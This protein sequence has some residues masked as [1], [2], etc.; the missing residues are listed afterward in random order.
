M[1]RV[2]PNVYM[3]SK[4]PSSKSLRNSGSLKGTWSQEMF[5]KETSR[6]V[7]L[8]DISDDEQCPLDY[9][10]NINVNIT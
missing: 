1:K 10:I 8:R 5:V 4:L 2:I 7:L 9:S 6:A 3:G